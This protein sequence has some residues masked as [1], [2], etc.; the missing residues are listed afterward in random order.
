MLSRRAAADLLRGFDCGAVDPAEVMASPVVVVDATS[1]GPAQ[2]LKVSPVFPAVVVA[3][4][5]DRAPGLPVGGPDAAVTAASHPPRPWVETADPGRAVDQLIQRVQV[6]PQ[7]AVS[8]AQ[9]LRAGTGRSVVTGLLLE[10]VAYSMLQAGPEFQMWKKG[11]PPPSPRPHHGPAVVV[12]RSGDRMAITLNRPE[13]HNA[14]NR[15]MRDELY[16]ALA[17][18][19]ADT[20]CTVLLSGAG[21]SFCSGGDLDEFGTFPDPVTSHAVRTGRSPARLIAAAADRITAVVHGNC[22]GSGIELP[23]F[24]GYV[25]ARPD[26]RIWLPE[27]AMGL[28]PGAGGTVSLAGRIGPGRAAWMGLSGQPINAATARDWGLVDRVDDSAG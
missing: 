25:V 2:E 28:I 19:V 24:A 16:D 27:V 7:A 10:S 18:A 17:V 1:P 5:G 6:A 11:R 26:A 15:Q 20:R 23:A 13:V 9:V 8:L 4:G 22:A 21:P 3:Y 12:E 14:Y